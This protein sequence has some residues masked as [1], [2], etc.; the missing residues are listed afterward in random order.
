MHPNV[1]NWIESTWIRWSSLQ[2]LS[3]YIQVHTVYYLEMT[4][5]PKWKEHEDWSSI[6]GGRELPPRT[7]RMHRRRTRRVRPKLFGSYEKWSNCFDMILLSYHEKKMEQLNSI[8]WHRCLPQDSRLLRIGQFQHGWVIC[9]EEVVPRRNFSIAW[10]LILRPFIPSTNSR[11]LWRRSHQSNITVQRV[12]TERLRR[13]HL[14]RWMLQRHALNHPIWIDSGWKRLRKGD[15]RYSSLP[16]IQCPFFYKSKGV[17]TWRSPELQCS[18]KIGKYTRTQCSG[19]TGPVWQL[20]RRDWRSFLPDLTRWSFTTL[21]QRCVLRRWWSWIH[22]KIIQQSLWISSFTAKNRT[23]TSLARWTT[24]YC[25]HWRKAPNAQ[26]KVWRPA[27]V[28]STVGF[29]D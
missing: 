16:W 2:T 9:N 28:K 14:P 19:L 3:L 7:S 23:E 18:N 20:F 5:Y 29:M 1:C 11:P 12:V 27:P 26:P 10:I 17:R 15:R 21:Y 22:E 6:G 24:G 13:I 4:N 25:K 8:F